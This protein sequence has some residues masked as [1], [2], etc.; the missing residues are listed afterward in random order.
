M[1]AFTTTFELVCM[2]KASIDMK[3]RAVV[4]SQEGVKTDKEIRSSCGTSERTLKRCKRAYSK[5]G[6]EGLRPS[7]TAPKKSA[8]ATRTNV[9][10]RVLALKQKYPNWEARGSNTSFICQYSGGQPTELLESMAC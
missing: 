3:T 9:E 8:N 10:K 2:A 5:G 1:S 4:L 7:S 6:L